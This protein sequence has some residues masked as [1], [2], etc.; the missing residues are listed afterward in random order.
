MTDFGW[1]IFGENSSAQDTEKYC[2]IA[3]LWEINGDYKSIPLSEEDQYCLD[4]FSR[5]VIRDNNRFVVTIPLK[6]NASLGDSKP[7]ALRW[8]I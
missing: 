5:N 8:L 3:K 1:I 4:D 7:I 2:M 6:A